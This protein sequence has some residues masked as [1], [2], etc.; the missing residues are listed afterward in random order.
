VGKFDEDVKD[1]SRAFQSKMRELNEKKKQTI[2]FCE[3][4]LTNAEVESE[5]DS[6]V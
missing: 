1:L 6:I 4:I 3:E 2:G 5:K